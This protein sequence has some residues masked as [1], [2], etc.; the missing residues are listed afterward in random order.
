MGLGQVVQASC[1]SVSLLLF[2]PILVTEQP[3]SAEMLRLC[4]CRGV[5]RDCLHVTEALGADMRL[6][7]PLMLGGMPVRII[8]LCTAPLLPAPSPPRG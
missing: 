1:F 7:S 2:D 3:L 4:P 8:Y 6:C 5:E